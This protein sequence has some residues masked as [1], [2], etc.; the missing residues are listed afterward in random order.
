MEKYTFTY[1]KKEFKE[2]CLRAWW[3]MQRRR[4]IAFLAFL[5]LFVSYALILR[6]FPYEILLLIIMAISLEL[7][8]LYNKMHKRTGI[9]RVFCLDRRRIFQVPQR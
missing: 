2:F 1:T 3:E 4:P 9:A 8:I 7:G 5:L 6:R